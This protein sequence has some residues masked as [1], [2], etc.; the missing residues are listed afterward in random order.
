[1][2]TYTS[3]STLQTPKSA[4]R[5]C[6]PSGKENGNSRL[7]PANLA[8][9]SLLRGLGCRFSA[10]NEDDAEANLPEF[11]RIKKPIPISEWRDAACLFAPTT[12]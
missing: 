11:Q 6:E 4:E 7:G 8:E 10:R 1:M 9:K 12:A 5:F 2:V 3:P